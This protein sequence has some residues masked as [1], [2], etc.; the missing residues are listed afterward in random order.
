[1]QLVNTERQKAGLSPLTLDSTL[2]ANAKLRAQEIVTH[3]SHTRPN[4]TQFSTAITIPWRTVGE[5]I[6]WGQRTPQEV[7]NGWMNSKGHRDNILKSSYTKLGVGV[8]ESGGRLYWVQ[9]FVG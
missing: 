2:S 6:A 7:M 8:Y 5:N 9:L 3:F 4:G 1:M